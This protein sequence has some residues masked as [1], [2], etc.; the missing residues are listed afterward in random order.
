MG[1]QQETFIHELNLQEEGTL[2]LRES[3]MIIPGIQAMF[4]FQLIAVF[5]EGFG[6]RLQNHHEII[7]LMAMVLVLIAI[8][9]VMTPAV[10]QRRVEPRKISPGFIRLSNNML[11][12]GL[13]AFTLGLAADVGVITY[14]VTEKDSVAMLLGFGSLAFLVWLWFFFGSPVNIN[15]EP[16]KRLLSSSKK[17]FD[18]AAAIAL[19]TGK[20]HY[21]RYKTSVMNAGYKYLN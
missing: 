18:T 9:L 3:R 6:Q 16:G 4:G 19:K 17:H 14:A 12:W 13:R 1:T 8:A 11:A 21:N 5:S 7:H 2:I 10:Y 20:K 15:Y